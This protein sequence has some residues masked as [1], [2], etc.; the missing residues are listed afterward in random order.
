MGLV[1]LANVLQMA[2]DFYTIQSHPDALRL[3]RQVGPILSVFSADP[4][5]LIAMV[6]LDCHSWA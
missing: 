1:I 4:L 2:C 6:G 3:F 5:G